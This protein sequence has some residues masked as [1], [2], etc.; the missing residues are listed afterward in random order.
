LPIRKGKGVLKTGLTG[1]WRWFGKLKSGH[2]WLL[3][4]MG[5]AG[6]ALFGSL[7]G[8]TGNHAAN[9]SLCT[10]VPHYPSGVWYVAGI[11]PDAGNKTY[12][13]E[14]FNRQIVFDDFVS[15]TWREGLGDYDY[16]KHR[17]CA[18]QVAPFSLSKKLAPGRVTLTYHHGDMTTLEA[19]RCAQEKDRTFESDN[20]LNVSS[21]GC[22]MSGPF[23]SNTANGT[24]L[25]CWGEK[26]C[27][28][29]PAQGWS[30]VGPRG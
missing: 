24:V 5:A 27:K 10:T 11:L 18:D 26:P 3:G 2:L 14:E 4:G 7:V 28:V 20:T 6:A 8:L 21:D 23:K 13:P 22:S 15:G 19:M 17:Y 16:T 30:Q 9:P 25:Y 1:I 12:W 29:D